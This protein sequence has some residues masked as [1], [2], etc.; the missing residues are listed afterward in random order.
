M[1]QKNKNSSQHPWNKYN[2][3]KEKNPLQAK[4]DH[5]HPEK[6]IEKWKKTRDEWRELNKMEM[7]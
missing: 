6:N 3:R 1:T 7:E 5:Y 2:Q 4:V